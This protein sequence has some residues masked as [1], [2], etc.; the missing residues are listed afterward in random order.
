MEQ[1]KQD[2]TS[3]V[4]QPQPLQNENTMDKVSTEDTSTRSI[5]SFILLELR[6]LSDA[7]ASLSKLVSD[8]IFDK[9]SK[10]DE[11]PPNKGSNPHGFSSSS[12]IP[13]LMSL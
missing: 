10:C 9:S 7:Q 1:A 6:K 3:K 4:S 8:F 2:I 13:P 5:L 12:H 11:K